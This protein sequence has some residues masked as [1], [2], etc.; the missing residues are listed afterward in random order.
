MNRRDHERVIMLN[1]LNDVCDVRRAMKDLKLSARE[2]ADQALAIRAKVVR[3][4]GG[5][6]RFTGNNRVFA[7]GTIASEVRCPQCQRTFWVTELPY[8]F[9]PDCDVH[10]RLR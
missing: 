5:P 9:C 4:L 8:A 7:N 2:F 3:A 10:C 1:R 6:A